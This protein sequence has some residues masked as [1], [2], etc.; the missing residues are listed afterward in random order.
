MPLLLPGSPGGLALETRAK[1]PIPNEVRPELPTVV[2]EASVELHKES[3]PDANLRSLTGT[4]NCMG[5]VVANR[6]VWVDP[7]HF[8]QILQGDGY[9]K[10][11]GVKEVEPGDVVVY[12]DHKGEI[13]HVGIVVRKNVVIPGEQEEPLQVLS[14]WGAD[15]E[16]THGM[17]AVPFYLGKPAEFW[18]DRKGVKRC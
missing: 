12:R 10:L 3:F 13:C 9:R 1:W 6:R 5:P 15:G 7:E 14:K 17:S 2:L 16:Y 11:R 8:V 18:T 4:Y